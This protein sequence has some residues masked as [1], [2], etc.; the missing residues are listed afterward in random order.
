MEES[1]GLQ[2][3]SQV[4]DAVLTVDPVCGLKLDQAKAHYKTGYAGETFCFCSQDCQKKFEEEPGRF[5]GQRV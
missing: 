4:G 1:W 5:I 2:D 3:Y